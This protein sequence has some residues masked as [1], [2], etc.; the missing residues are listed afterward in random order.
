MLAALHQQQQLLLVVVVSMG[1]G[2]VGRR[3][4][5]VCR[6]ASSQGQQDLV[7][8]MIGASSTQAGVGSTA[9]VNV[10]QHLVVAVT[11][12]LQQS[13]SVAGH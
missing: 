9:G 3:A 12:G 7:S 5:H 1:M 2:M 11:V 8:M 13:S 6:Q 10:Q 4:G